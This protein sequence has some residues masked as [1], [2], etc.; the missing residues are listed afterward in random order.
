MKALKTIRIAILSSALLIGSVF[1][2]AIVGA[3]PG[4]PNA[5]QTCTAMG[6]FGLTHGACVSFMSSGDMTGAAYQ[7]RCEQIQAEIPELYD[8]PANIDYSTTPPTNYGGFGGTKGSCLN[9]L[10]GYHTGTLTHPE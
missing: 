7:E 3:E 8:M 10:R 1:S 4:Q 2:A 5:S 6:N 9:I